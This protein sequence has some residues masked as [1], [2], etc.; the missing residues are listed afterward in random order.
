M[1]ALREIER[2]RNQGVLGATADYARDTLLPRLAGVGASVATLLNPFEL[3]NLGWGEVLPGGKHPLSTSYWLDRLNP[4]ILQSAEAKAA[5]HAT[6]IA[7]AVASAPLLIKGGLELTRTGRNLGRYLQG[8]GDGVSAAAD[9]IQRAM[10]KASNNLATLDGRAVLGPNTEWRALATDRGWVSPV[11]TGQGS[12]PLP[13]GRNYTQDIHT[14]PMGPLGQLYQI[15]PA[16][17]ENAAGRTVT[18]IHSSPYGLTPFQDTVRP[19]IDMVASLYE[20]TL[21]SQYRAALGERFRGTAPTHRYL[22]EPYAGLAALRGDATH[23]IKRKGG[24]WV[25]GSVEDA[26]R[27]LKVWPYDTTQEQMDRRAAINQWIE[28]PLTK[29]VKNLMATPEDPVRALAE[30]GVLHFAPYNNPIHRAQAMRELA[31]SQGGMQPTRLAVS[32]LAQNWENLSDALVLQ[33]SYLDHLP[34]DR[35]GNGSVKAALEKQFGKFAADNPHTLA[36]KWDRDGAFPGFDLLVRELRNAINPE[37][38]LPRSL[39]IDPNKL[40][41]MNMEAAVQHVAK[42][43]KWR[44]EQEILLN[45][46]RANNAAIILYKDYPDSDYKWVRLGSDDP[47]YLKD[48][49]ETEDNYR[50]ALQD[51]LKHEGDTMGHCVGGY[52]DKIMRGDAQIY[53]L[54]NKKTGESHVTIEV[55]TKPEDPWFDAPQSL[56]DQWSAQAHREARAN[57]LAE[58]SDEYMEFVMGRLLDLA[59]G[60]A[61]T[62]TEPRILQ[63]KG[64]QNL[65]PKEEYLPFVRDFEEEIAALRGKG[66]ASGG[67]VT[68]PIRIPPG[69]ETAAAG[70]RGRAWDI[71]GE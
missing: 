45:Q 7:G 35:I 24:N 11:T 63:I 20:G 50:R 37:S 60:W 71:L 4:E 61:Q 30:R 2:K 13:K 6:D 70:I 32:P 49:F 65:A 3:Y 58:D 62:Q 18:V 10:R 34:T 23:V 53:S 8:G 29:Y 44:A 52:C 14:H 42:I 43:N 27:G 5:R 47:D 68:S 15:H 39:Q 36:Y 19:G 16:D 28:G 66:Y 55:G 41:R 21:P 69:T 57:N 64:K 25:P 59:D 26:L 1:Q 51:A 9:E 46:Q 67:R 40:G 31:A 33:A 22:D 56:R 38:G 12:T 48:Y 54:R 17:V